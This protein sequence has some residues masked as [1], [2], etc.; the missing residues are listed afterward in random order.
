MRKLKWR[1]YL[2]ACLMIMLFQ[3]CDQNEITLNGDKNYPTT[4]KKQDANALQQLR[5]DFAKANPYLSSSITDFGFCGSTQNYRTTPWPTRIPDLTKAE[6]ITATKVFISQNTALLG[7]KSTDNITFNRVDS[8]TIYEGS[9][10]WYLYSDTQKIGDLEVYDTYL[11]FS[12]TNGKM[13][14][15]D[16]N[17]YPYIYIPARQNINEAKAKSILL[18]KVVYLSDFSGSPIPMTITAKSLETAQFSKLIDPIKTTDKI[19]LH[20]VW[21]VSIPEVFYVIYLDVM[22]GEIVGGYPTIVS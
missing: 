19:E 20:V 8:F 21:V 1:N 10:K 14:S 3:S 13:T 16:G 15:C 18:N 7:V 12:L 17:W 22:T 2:A 4:Y 6:A 5:T 9:L 11:R